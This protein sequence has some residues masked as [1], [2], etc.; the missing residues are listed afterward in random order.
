MAT[1]ADA[2][3]PNRPRK[4]LK[5]RSEENFECPNYRQI[6]CDLHSHLIF[7]AAHQ[8]SRNPI[9]RE[10]TFPRYSTE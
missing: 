1:F 3:L 10:P 4:P 9:G 8:Y 6:G 5:M 2:D 7:T